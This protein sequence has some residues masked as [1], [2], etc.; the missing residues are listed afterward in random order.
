MTQFAIARVSALPGS[1]AAS[2][3]YIIQDATDATLVQLYFTGTDG[4]EVRHALTKAEVVALIAA[5]TSGAADHLT[6]PRNISVTGDGTWT[7]SF[8]GS[9]DVTAA[10][11]LASVG[12]PGAQG[13]IVTTDAKG[14]TI[15][16][17]ALVAADIP[18]LPGSKITSI[19]SVDT[20]GNAATATLATNATAAAKLSTPR[21]INGVAFDGTANI[22]INA[23][24]ATA[25]IAA[26][27]KG[28]ANGVATLDS[29]GL[30]PSSQLPSYV[31]DVLEFANLAAFPGTGESGKIYVADDT[32]TIYR[33]TGTQYLAIPGGVGLADAAT[34]LATARA[35]ALSGD[36]TGT[37]NFD[38]TANVTIVTTLAAVGTAGAQGPVV[39][40]DA[41]G[42]VVSS[43]ALVAA[44]IPTLDYTKVTSA[45]SINLVT[46][47]W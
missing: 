4:S 39:T 6:T 25:R 36:A 34:K 37:V 15:S 21:N 17:R 23:V 35:I 40:T 3:M 2:T 31:D 45:A 5:S 46:A 9:A 28:A 42:R 1:P 7:V 8:D 47:D 41:K 44:D 43:R 11:T 30:V 13:G 29:S 19:L 14:R 10:L 16:S 38:G 18:S 32:G 24:D 33:W 12:T 26:T 22:T 27:E 20:T